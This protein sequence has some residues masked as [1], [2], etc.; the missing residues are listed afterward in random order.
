MVLSTD[1]TLSPTPLLTLT[2]LLLDATLVT[3]PSLSSSTARTPLSSSLN[4][5]DTE[6]SILNQSR[7][8]NAYQYFAPDTIYHYN[9]PH[10]LSVPPHSSSLTSS[11]TTFGSSTLS[12]T[13]KCLHLPNYKILLRKYLKCPSD[14][15]PTDDISSSSTPSVERQ[16][17]NTTTD[18]DDDI[19][20]CYEWCC[21][22]A[23]PNQSVLAM[24]TLSLEQPIPPPP[25]QPRRR[26]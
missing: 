6:S 18:H 13:T 5:Q 4:T 3:T 14:S 7:P 16:Q 24:S 1:M 22:L 15:E 8:L 19:T 23:T 10:L 25:P 2:P 12:S 17:G 9:T 20:D 11:S 26:R 21:P